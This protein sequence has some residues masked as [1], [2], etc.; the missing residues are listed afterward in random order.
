MPWK[1]AWCYQGNHLIGSDVTFVLSENCPIF[2]H[3][4][5]GEILSCLDCSFQTGLHSPESAR[6]AP[7]SILGLLFVRC[8]PR[9][10]SIIIIISSRHLC[11]TGCW[12]ST[13]KRQSPPP[14]KSC[15]L[16]EY[17][18][19]TRLTNFRPGNGS[20]AT[21]KLFTSSLCK[22]LSSQ[23]LDLA[24]EFTGYVFRC[25]HL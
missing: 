8:W 15:Q 3:I 12:T 7:L 19:A 21:F 10:F 22:L 5:S 20:L 6:S 9:W 18:K 14:W 23:F 25:S 1:R 2:G 24:L 13:D 17:K 11:S 16:D 4:M